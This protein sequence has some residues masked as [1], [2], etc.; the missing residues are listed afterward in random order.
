MTQPQVG[1]APG[2]PGRN[3]A[4]NTKCE[5]AAAMFTFTSWFQ[6]DPALQVSGARLKENLARAVGLNYTCG[7]IKDEL[8]L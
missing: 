1:N 3:E 5:R 7:L 6:Q 2:K 8:V 4:L